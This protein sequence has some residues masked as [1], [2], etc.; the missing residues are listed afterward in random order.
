VSISYLSR[1]AAEV[2]NDLAK[3]EAALANL[4]G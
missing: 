3:P 4:L 2:R 1:I